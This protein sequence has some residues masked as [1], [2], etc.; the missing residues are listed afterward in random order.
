MGGV[1]WGKE[2]CGGAA[3]VIDDKLNHFTLSVVCTPSLTEVT[4][5]D[6]AI[7]D[8]GCTSNFLSATPPCSNKQAA[9][10]PLNVNMPNGT[11]RIIFLSSRPHHWSNCQCQWCSKWV[12]Q[13]P[14]CA[15]GVTL[16]LICFLWR[17]SSASNSILVATHC[18]NRRMMRGCL[19]HTPNYRY[20]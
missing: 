16:A 5:N 8:S 15:R 2:W 4:T 13:S 17:D 19:E 10:V 18:R 14:V 7:L 3:N 12:L 6:T 20:Q 1:Q 11:K 9:H